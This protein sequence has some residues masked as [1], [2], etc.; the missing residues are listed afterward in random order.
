M[1]KA[2]IFD[3]DG[4]LSDSIMSM[5]YSGDKTMAEF[6]YGPFSVQEPTLLRFGG[7]NIRF[8][9]F[10]PKEIMFFYSKLRMLCCL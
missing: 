1:K 10:I 6:G 8:N 3:L 7:A 5:K 4:T 2:A 9:I